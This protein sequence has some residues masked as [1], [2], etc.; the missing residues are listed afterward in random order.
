MGL[1]LKKK[2]KK[3]WKNPITK[4]LTGGLVGGPVG[5]VAATA[6]VAGDMMKVPSPS[7]AG[8]QG[9]QIGRASCRERG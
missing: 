3:A 6:S 7:D 1:N 9:A 5:S 8:L 2:L 4:I